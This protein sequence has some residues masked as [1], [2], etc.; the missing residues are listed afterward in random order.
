MAI[1][2]LREPSVQDNPLYIFFDYKDTQNQTAEKVIANLLK[3]LIFVFRTIPDDLKTMY[4]KNKTESPKPTLS[5]LVHL[6]IIHAKLGSFIVLFDAFDECN[7]RPIVWSQIVR[8][9]YSSGIK[10]FVTHR[11][12]VLQGIESTV[13]E[14]RAQDE[15]IEKYI[16]QQI[17]MEEKVNHLTDTFKY[18]IMTDITKQANGM[19][20]SFSELH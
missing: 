20:N 6:F 7:E 3:Q 17:G 11:R 1:D 4:E 15:D 10:V 18:R 19:Y 16:A 2:Y 8:T 14:V 9:I 13:V 12:H 5:E